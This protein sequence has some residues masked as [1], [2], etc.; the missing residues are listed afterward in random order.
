MKQQRL[1]STC[2]KDVAEYDIA[3]IFLE[4]LENW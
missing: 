4:S 2:P 1:L 3:N